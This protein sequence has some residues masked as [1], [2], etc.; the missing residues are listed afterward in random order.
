MRVSLVR[1]AALT[2]LVALAAC[3]VGR[4]PAA[5]EPPPTPAALRAPPP[6]QR[7]RPP[8]DPLAQFYAAVETDLTATGR[9]RRDTAPGDAPFGAP[10]LVRNFE[11]I[12]LY[13]EYVEV[14]GR[15]IRRPTPARLRRWERPVRVG[16]VMGASVPSAQAA[17]DRARVER[18]TERLARLTGLD[19]GMSPRDED[20]NFL[21]LFLSQEEQAA[22]ADQ[23]ALSLPGMDPPVLD[24]IRAMP[25]DIFCTA[26]AFAQPGDPDS[27]SAVLI[28][29]KTEHPDL[30]RHSCIHEEM[31]QA[32]G[33]PSDYEGARPSLFN[34]SREFAFLTAH[35]EA[36]L[37]MLYDPRLRTGMTAAEAR[38]LLPAI[39]ADA[40]RAQGI[41]PPGV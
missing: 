14:A 25:V 30:T 11:R 41:A 16:V 3:D 27:Y 33:L 20:A 38:P 28:V 2:A 35:D 15:F 37:R 9:M 31:A 36:L 19:M 26:Y 1:A 34:T 8:D 10:E 4:V 7:P 29:I 22:F 39:A 12:A 32:M 18:F 13:D 23:A 6:V 21:V 17:Q 40:I 24:A 5:V